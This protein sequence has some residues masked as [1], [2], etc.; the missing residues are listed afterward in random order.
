[1]LSFQENDVCQRRLSTELCQLLKEP[2]VHY[3]EISLLKEVDH[4]IHMNNSNEIKI[5]Q[6]NT[7]R[8]GRPK[9]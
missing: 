1:M 4:V 2:V 8:R 5:Q 9:R 7:R 3:I 6:D